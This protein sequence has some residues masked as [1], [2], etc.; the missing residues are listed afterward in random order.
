VVSI[1][2]AKLS[3]ELVKGTMAVE[4]VLNIQAAGKAPQS[5]YLNASPTGQDVGDEAANSCFVPPRLCSSG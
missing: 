5:I 2:A 4:R 1:P 3:L